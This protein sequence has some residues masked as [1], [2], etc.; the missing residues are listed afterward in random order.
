MNVTHL[1]CA[2]CGLRHEAGVLQ[3]LCITCGKPLLV[4]YDLEKAGQTLTKESLRTRESNLWRFREVLPV[5]NEDNIV[6]LG[7]GWTPLFRVEKLASALPVK[8]NLFIKDE[9]QN[10]TQSFKARGMTTAISMAKELGVKKLAVPSAGNAAGA[11]AA[12]AAKAGMEAFIFMPSDTPRA[13][14]VECQQTGA[15]VTLVDG[16][17]TDCGKIIAERKEAEGWF[18]VSTLKEPYRVEGKK[19]MG[20]ELAEQFDWTLPDV[21]LYPTGGGTGLIGMWKAFDEMEKMGWVGSKRPKMVSVQSETCAPIVRAFEKGERFA[22]ESKGIALA[23]V[24]GGQ[25]TEI[26]DDTRDVLIESAYFAPTNIR[27][28]SKALGLRSESSYRFERGADPGVTEWAS[29][30]AAQLILET[31]GGRLV[32]GVIDA[33]A[34]E[35]KPKE[36]TLR[37]HK[38]NQLLGI[39]LR[40]EEI[41]FHLGQLGLKVANPRIRP[42]GDDSPCEPVTFRIPTFRVDLK[43]EVDLIEE[44]ARLHGVDKIPGTPPRGAIGSH[45]FDAVHDQ[46]SDVRRVLTSLGLDETQG[47]TLLG[48]DECRMTNGEV[49]ALANP[50]S[51]E[52]DVLRPSLLPGLLNI[53]RHNASRQSHDLAL[54]EIGRVFTQAGGRPHEERRVAIA[55]TGRRAQD[56]WTG[57]DRDARCDVH[58]LKGMVE[59]VLEHFGL[60]GVAFDKRAESTPLFLESAA[61]ALGGKLALGEMGQLLPAL[62]KKHDLRDTVFLA[63]LRLD[64]LL[65]RRNATKAFKPLP[66]FPAVRRDVAMLVPEATTHDAVLATVRQAKPANLEG[67]ELFDVFR[68]KNV[69]EGEKSLAYAFTYRHAERT[70]TD[71]EVNAAHEKLVA[72]F[73]QKLQATVRDS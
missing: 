58:D 62:A 4:R 41:E 39:P 34:V 9:G 15:H 61:I 28:T 49:I 26:R 6:T 47:Q 10:P 52:M 51:S 1:E 7:E 37:H 55:I 65:A 54:F 69:P 16:L 27:R 67:A 56:F 33:C 14:T 68:G 63:E 50:L 30:R 59:E 40:P 18:D 21:I 44:V 72:D 29:R 23:G 70:L 36:I 22:D 32:P 3:N 11:L 46:I 5:E 20:Y 12:Y 48:N 53:L 66:Q 64:E 19:T 73:K 8:L 42:V 24:M 35:I 43:R 38:V 17:I 13:N 31:A 45:P 25:N 60:R 57:A 71:A 2:L